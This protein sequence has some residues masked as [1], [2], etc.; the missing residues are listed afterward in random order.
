MWGVSAGEVAS[1]CQGPSAA[2][3][4]RLLQQGRT[5]TLGIRLVTRVRGLVPAQADVTDGG[6]AITNGTFA[7]LVAQHLGNTVLFVPRAPTDQQPTCIAGM[8]CHI[9]KPPPP[10]AAAPTRKRPPPPKAKPPPPRRAP[11]PPPPT[12][13]PSGNAALFLVGR[14]GCKSGGGW[15]WWWWSGGWVGG[16]AGGCSWLRCQ[17]VTSSLT[18]EKHGL[19]TCYPALMLCIQLENGAAPVHPPVPAPYRLCLGTVHLR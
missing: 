16:R 19:H 11:S 15:V 17:G 8:T 1:A 7:R 4:R 10:P 6:A 3:G 18:S 13:N 5:I 12:P 2:A 9:S 14:Q